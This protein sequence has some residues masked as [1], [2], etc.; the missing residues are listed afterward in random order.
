MSSENFLP[1]YKSRET[2]TARGNTLQCLKRGKAVPA[3]PEEIVRQRI[4]NWLL[5]VKKWPIGKVELERSYEWVGDPN[6]QRIRPDIE[7]LGDDDET[8]VVIECKARGV[9]LVEA[10][11]KQAQRYALKSD[12]RYIW[13]SNGDQHKF[14]VRSSRRKWDSTSSLEPLAAT[15]APPSVNFEFPDPEDEK[16]VDRYFEHSFPDNGFAT[17]GYNNKQIVLAVHKLL[18]DMPEKEL[19]FSFDGVHVLEDWGVNQHHFS[20]PG[21][22]RGFWGLYADYVAAT[23]GRVEAL[24]VAVHT[25]SV[26]ADSIRLCVGIRRS[27]SSSHALQV[28][29]GECEWVED[30]DCWEVYHTGKM[31]PMGKGA[32]ITKQMVF[33]AVEEA[34]AGVWLENP[35]GYNDCLYLG[36][37]YWA[38]AASWE[39]SK[40]LL[41][42]LLHYGIIRT[43]LKDAVKGR[44]S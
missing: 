11:E 37:L 10:V 9:P 6:R 23:S 16:A 41:A 20:T 15:Y 22:G 28:D 24:S 42:N 34:G 25:W 27:G 39:N 30:R 43:N 29:M 31:P 7:L 33:D 2:Q 18:F 32:G 44:N 14:L 1:A 40:Q 36:N 26:E 35:H 8:I 13:I 19:P 21:R 4:L 12:A 17:L 38:S 3:T 5:N